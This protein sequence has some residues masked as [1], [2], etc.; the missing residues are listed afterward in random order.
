[1]T[2]VVKRIALAAVLASVLAAAALAGSYQSATG[3][4][5]HLA[6]TSGAAS[7]QLSIDPAQLNSITTTKA[8]AGWTKRQIAN[9]AVIVARGLAKNVPPRGMV[10]A[11]ATAMQ[12]SGLRI[13]ANP[14]VPASL[15]FPHDGVGR[16]HD[17]LNL[18]QQRPSS[19]WGTVAHLM[20]PGYAADAFYSHLVKVPSWQSLD[21]TVAAQTV[22]NSAFP[23][24][25]AN[26]TTPAS[27][28]TAALG[29]LDPGAVTGCPS[30]TGT[31]A[32]GSVRATIVAAAR[33][34]IGLPYVFFAGDATGPTKALGGCDAA[35]IGGCAAVGFDCSGLSLYAWAQAGIALDHYAATQYTQ[36]R[37][38]PVHDAQPGDLLFYA[39]NPADIA[40]IHHVT[41]YVGNGNMVEAPQS[42]QRLLETAVRNDAELMPMAAQP[43]ARKDR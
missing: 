29:N 21:V 14:T 6:S 39:T 37:H 30:D 33:K 16:D 11:L 27:Q 42:G 7:C 3:G 4:S 22:Q 1:M 13:L 35:A 28:F 9:A 10:I 15:A 38:V 18:F 25:Y 17:S 24:A 20:D 19:G 23:D 34:Y 12:E 8:M 26:W 5:S 36:G 2:F 40:S 43:T 32:A 41:V 31:L